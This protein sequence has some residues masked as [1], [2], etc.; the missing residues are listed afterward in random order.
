VWLV[1]PVALTIGTTYL[2]ARSINRRFARI[3]RALKPDGALGGEP[4]R[5]N[6]GGSSDLF[7]S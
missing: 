1:I 6:R 7:R 4:F 3:V 2:V 5:G